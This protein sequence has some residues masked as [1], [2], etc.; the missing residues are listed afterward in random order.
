KMAEENFPT[1]TRTDDQL[2]LVKARLPIGKINLLMDLQKMQKNPIF[3]ILQF[4]NTLTMDTK[5]SVYSFQLDEL[6]FTLNADLLYSAL[7][8]TPKDPT[9][10]FVAPP[11]RDLS[12]SAV[13]NHSF[14]DQ[15]MLNGQD[16]CHNLK[17]PTKMPKPRVIPYCR[18]TKLIICYLG[19]RHN[20]H[21][22]PQ[23]LLHITTD[24][25]SLNNLKFLPKGELDEVFGMPIPKDLITDVICNSEY[26]QKYLEMVARK[27]HQATT[28]IDE[29]GGKKKK[30]PLAGKSKQHAR[31]KQ[32]APAK[33]S[34]PMKETTSKPTPSKKIC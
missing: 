9:H 24:D 28:V 11:T 8:I 25:Y 18:F 5:S 29:E 10:P 12:I 19:G 17:V 4:W 30:A 32:L 22:R 13:E 6:W 27:P 23:S 20:I 14:Y 26:Y 33:Q 21:K 1:P 7:G 3:C 34:K 15:P 31:A 16:F 2:V